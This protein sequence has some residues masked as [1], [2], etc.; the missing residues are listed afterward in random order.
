MKNLIWLC[1]L[2]TACMPESKQEQVRYYFDLQD[3]L[4]KLEKPQ[5][6][7]LKT[8]ISEGKSQVKEIRTIEWQKELAFFEQANL[9]KSVFRGSYTETK[10]WKQDTI[11]IHYRTQNGELKVKN[12]TIA[13]LNDSSLVKVEAFISTDNYLYSS[14]KKLQ[15]ICKN[16]KVESYHIRGKQKMIFTKP[17]FFEVKAELMK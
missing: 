17:E 6:N 8:T 11:F 9:N 2:L 12:L 15:L 3:A 5:T 13:L 16:N 4:H 1:C 7:F 14:E 10:S